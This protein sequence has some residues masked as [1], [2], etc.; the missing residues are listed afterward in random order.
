MHYYHYYYYYRYYSSEPSAP[1]YVTTWY[2]IFV[3]LYG[4]YSIIIVSLYGTYSIIFVS[5]QFI[6]YY[7]ITLNIGT[8]NTL[9][10]LLKS[11]YGYKFTWV[12][13]KSGLLEPF[14]PFEL[15]VKSVLSLVLLL[16]TI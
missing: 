9:S 5:F 4:T 14:V 15:V 13:F 6:W 3:S 8:F 7:I 2:I 12:K 16:V 1:I 10:K 11:F